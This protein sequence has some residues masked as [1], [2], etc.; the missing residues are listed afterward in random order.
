MM[1][2]K[3][4][5]IPVS[6]SLQRYLSSEPDA[7]AALHIH[8]TGMIL[9]SCLSQLSLTFLSLFTSPPIASADSSAG[10]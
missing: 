6:P 10:T 9:T 3:G 8:H 1:N 5:M 2:M 7:C 4:G